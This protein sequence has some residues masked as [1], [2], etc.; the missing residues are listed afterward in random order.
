MPAE[1]T[2][3]C[4]SC[5]RALY[6]RKRVACGYCGAVIPS[7]LRLPEAVRHALE[8]GDFSEKDRLRLRKDSAD[9][10]DL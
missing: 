5:E 8:R 10:F 6:D 4:P 2:F 9:S 1:N 7:E 3:T